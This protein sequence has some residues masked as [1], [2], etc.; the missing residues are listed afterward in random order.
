MIFTD[1][2]EVKGQAVPANVSVSLA[3]VWRATDQAAG[4]GE[5]IETERL[6]AQ[7][8]PDTELHTRGAVY[9][10]QGVDYVSYEPPHK[11]VVHGEIHHLTITLYRNTTS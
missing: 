1:T 11:R 8:E 9:R 6:R 5:Y 4:L 3:Q 7:V 2:I 10:W